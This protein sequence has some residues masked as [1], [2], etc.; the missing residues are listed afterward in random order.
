MIENDFG[1]I[2]PD[3]Y[4]KKA[5][6]YQ[7][8]EQVITFIR[9]PGRRLY[10]ANIALALAV[11]E[12]RTTVDLVGDKKL[13]EQLSK[14]RADIKLMTLLIDAWQAHEE[15]GVAMIELHPDWLV[16]TNNLIQAIK[17]YLNQRKPLALYKLCRKDYPLA[18]MLEPSDEPASMTGK[19][20][21]AAHLENYKHLDRTD[22]A[23]RLFE[24]LTALQNDGEP[25]SKVQ[26]D[27]LLA[28]GV[29]FPISRRDD[30]R[31][32]DRRRQFLNRCHKEWLAKKDL[33]KN[34]SR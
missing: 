9:G 20:A 27:A 31:K 17:V 16:Y 26:G 6:I 1:L 19:D 14:P 12:I 29:Y 33:S 18:R 30:L 25:L 10:L 4:D 5:L 21:I 32:Q 11:N 28:L 3:D 8:Q 15:I 24:D 22:A 7:G 34:V 13:R 23:E 2:V